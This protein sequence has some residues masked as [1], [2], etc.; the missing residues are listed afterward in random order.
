MLNNNKY[1]YIS[2]F[3][4]ALV[5]AIILMSLIWTGFF[6]EEKFDFS[7]KIIN[8]TDDD[9]W[10]EGE[11]S[12][13][14]KNNDKE[15]VKGIHSLV[16]KNFFASINNSFNVNYE[17]LSVTIYAENYSKYIAD[18]NIYDTE[19]WDVYN[20]S[21]ENIAGLLVNINLKDQTVFFKEYYD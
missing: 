21:Q 14:D 12:Y 5:I 19:T 2:A 6:K 4:V 16:G 20:F 7:I 13:K 1:Y 11:I 18:S 9:L 15:F 8:E 3:I 17:I 10:V